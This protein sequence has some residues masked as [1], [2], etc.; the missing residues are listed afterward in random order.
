MC[1]AG[2]PPMLLVHVCQCERAPLA[3]LLLCTHTAFMNICYFYICTCTVDCFCSQNA[4]FTPEM[5]GLA[6]ACYFDFGQSKKKK[7]I[8]HRCND[9]MIKAWH[10]AFLYGIFCCCYHPS[11]GSK[12]SSVALKY[13][14]PS[15]SLTVL[16]STL[17]LFENCI[18]L[19]LLGILGQFSAC[20]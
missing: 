17:T 19:P 15:V 8:G 20:G 11:L 2:R 14:D 4:Q 5:L 16:Y 10:F 3:R 9:A 1:R 7:Y 6:L 18:Q 13:S 12:A